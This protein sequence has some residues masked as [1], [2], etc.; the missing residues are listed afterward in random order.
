M[1]SLALTSQNKS[2]SED[3]KN[4]LASNFQASDGTIP[5]SI[6]ALKSPTN[7]SNVK[8]FLLIK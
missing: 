3:L 6:F 1:R 8:K 4:D 2:I 7:S 5:A